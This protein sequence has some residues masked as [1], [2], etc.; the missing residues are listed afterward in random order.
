MAEREKADADAMNKKYSDEMKRKYDRQRRERREAE[1]RR[2]PLIG[3]PVSPGTPPVPVPTIPL[4][5][6]G[7]SDGS[8]A[9]EHHG[10]LMGIDLYGGGVPVSYTPVPLGYPGETQPGSL[11]LYGGYSALATYQDDSAA[12]PMEDVNGDGNVDA[13]DYETFTQDGFSAGSFGDSVH[14]EGDLR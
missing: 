7:N 11:L 10:S 4:D 5:P 14:L 8:D 3:P 9:E 12:F 6:P 1:K 13:A 2:G